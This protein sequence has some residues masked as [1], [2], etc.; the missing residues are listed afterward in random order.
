MS[1]TKVLCG[2]TFNRI[3]EGHVYFLKKAKALGN[4]LVVIVA[5]DSHNK[6]PYAVPQEKRKHE[7]EK[8]GIADKVLIGDPDKFV[9]VVEEEKPQIIALGYDQALPKDVGKKIQGMKIKVVRIKR[10]HGYST[11]KIAAK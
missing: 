5:N 9:G 6:K 1:K 4:E 11:R 3:H 8:L 7:I 10:L 2:G